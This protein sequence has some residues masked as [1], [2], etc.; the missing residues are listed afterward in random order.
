MKITISENPSVKETEI[1]IVC[2]ELTDELRDIVASIGMIGQT[3][4]GKI[5]DETFFV[6]I[7]DIYYFESVEGT[8]FFYTEKT[9]YE[10]TAKLY[11]IEDS[12][13]HFKF[14]RISKTVIVNLEKMLSIKKHKNSRLTATLKNQEKI[15]VSRQYVNEIK[16]KLGV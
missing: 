7:Q 13:E 12:L 14:A 8:I 2:S 4:A 9:T 5:G 15:L 1:T 3:F 16:R 6:P 11:K 10:S